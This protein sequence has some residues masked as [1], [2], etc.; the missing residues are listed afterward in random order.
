[1]K[2]QLIFVFALVITVA[3]FALSAFAS[4]VYNI[5]QIT[6]P[7][8]N[9]QSGDVIDIVLGADIEF[10]ETVTINK[11]ITVNI[12][13]NGKQLNYK[14][15]AGANTHIGGF[16]VTNPGAT[17]NLKGSNLLA[18][19]KSYTHYGQDVKADYIGT[20]NLISI[21]KGILNIENAYFYATNDTFVINS[22]PVNG[23]DC[24]I[25]VDSSVLRT[26]EGAQT[27]AITVK[28]T[29]RTNDIGGL[30]KRDVILKNSVE[31]GG[32]FGTN[33]NFNLTAGSSFTNVKFYDFYIK[34][35]CWYDPNHSGTMN[36]FEKALLI[37][38][39]VFSTYGEE[40]GTV[41]VYTETGKQ[42]IKLYNCD[43]ASVE[44]GGKF[45]GDKGGTA[46]IYIVE[47]MPSCLEGGLTYSYSN[48][49]SSTGGKPM[50]DY[51]KDSWELN[52]LDHKYEKERVAYKNGYAN[53]GRGVSKCSLCM[54][55]YETDSVFDPVFENLGYSVNE[56]GNSMT[57][58]VKLHKEV[59]DYYL[60]NTQ[61]TAFD[62]GIVVGGKA[63]ELTV[64]N[65]R[66]NA[67]GGYLVSFKNNSCQYFDLKI[68]GFKDNNKAT[69]FMAEFYVYDGTE[70]TYAK[71]AHKEIE[72]VTFNGI[73]DTIDEV[74]VKVNKLL[75]SKHKLYYNDDG[76]F[77]VMILADLHISPSS[78]TTEVENRIKLL[79]DRENPNLI[80]FTGDNTW[81]ASNEASLRKCLDK[82]VGYIEEKKIPWCHVYGNHDREAGVS[83][84]MQQ[85]IYESYEY[86]IS[87]DEGG[88]DLW[89]VGN[90]V[91]GIY[92]KN[93]TLGSVIYFLDSGTSNSTYSY[94]YIHEDQIAWYKETSELLQEYNG[95]K[96][97]KG[98]MAF[99]IP[100]LE[101][102]KAY[103]NKDNKEIVYNYTGDRYEGICPSY[104]D[105]DLFETIL[106]RGDVK[107]IVTGHDHNN[108]YM[109]N[110]YGVKL[111]SAVTISKLGYSNS[112]DHEG[113]RIF[114]MDL[115]T[116]NDVTTY[117]SYIVERVNPDKYGAYDKNVSFDSGSV[118]FESTGYD[119][120][121]LNGS[122]TAQIVDGKIELVR[123]TGGN[124]E[125]NICFS[126]E[127]YGKLG[128]NK[129]LVLWVDFTNVDFRKACFGLLSSNG[130][131]PYRTDDY[132]SNSPFYYLAQGES[133]WTQ[134]S[135]G[136][137]G[138]FGTAQ[139]SSMIGKCGYLALPVEY[140]HYGSRIVDENTLVTGIYFYCDVNNGA[141]KPFY[142]DKIQLVENYK[143]IK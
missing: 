95:G 4:E 93:G 11:D 31:Y 47:K 71:Q 58:G 51:K 77:K 100:L 67:N 114:D 16:Y 103:E 84:Q 49:D 23:A 39:C 63:L 135:H 124:S 142:F 14:G 41:K 113:A 3:C 101:N 98:I 36:S 65:G 42:N 45:S 96:A 6:E 19:P 10:S 123:S 72:M 26:R 15:T 126:E 2:K 78:D 81:G 46:H 143:D 140:F 105:T 85:A 34:N 116:I 37:S 109:Y 1:M 24:V 120:N 89:G 35:D 56:A 79:V 21:E 94:D 32:F 12:D 107:A 20:G 22:E 66:V 134:I 17:L 91:H 128:E 30:V 111:C 88:D 90:Y 29:N 87:K 136:N 13:F 53:A 92:N 40:K 117:T 43:F 80:I 54:L 70:L 119:N 68:V 55:D 27:S 104:Y 33:Y 74:K 127:M 130:T 121:N 137:D 59:L 28:G 122:F 7:I 97:V 69:E 132:D 133:E 44:N 61:N 76:S 73:V 9:A 83:N 129:Y 5:S 75:E 139:S 64:E 60:E 8:N 106:E 125:M 86:C 52:V 112:A 50:Q 62:F 110:Y 57:L 82:M 108:D 115:K 48:Y 131:V 138:C 102:Q 18:D 25:T 141:G 38:D 99:H 118:Q